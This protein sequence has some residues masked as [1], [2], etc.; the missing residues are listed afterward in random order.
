MQVIDFIKGI[1]YKVINFP[2]GEK[3][4]KV[5]ELDR[6]DTVAIR[7]RIKSSDDLFL[8]MQLSDILS[9]QCVEVEEIKIFYLMSMRCDRVFSFEQ[10]FTLKIV[11]DVINSF[12]AKNVCIYE[13]HSQRSLDMIKNSQGFL[14]H[15]LSAIGLQNYDICFP[16][17]GAFER[18]TKNLP[19]QLFRPMICNKV[20]DV[21]SGKLLHFE[22]ADLGGYKEGNSIL[23][24]DD[25]CDGGGTFCGIAD[26]LRPLNPKR[27]GLF[28]THAVQYAGIKKVSEYYDNVYITNS[29]EG[30]TDLPS[31][32]KMIDITQ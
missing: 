1:G 32:V 9:R 17:N 2:D 27:I 23:V 6:K 26:L 14:L 28:I 21:E 29:Y 13:P 25:L 31:N 15:G 5:D 12:H 10:P 24:I 30:W 3:H 4:L 22:I 19:T 7:C 18:Y 20:R 11:A 16:D 8:L